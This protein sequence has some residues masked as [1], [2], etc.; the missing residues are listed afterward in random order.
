MRLAIVRQRYTPFGGA[1]RF[2]ERA[3]DAL[4]A[5][6]IEILLLTRHW[7][8]G[9][10]AKVTPQIVN[11]AYL[12][13]TMRDATFARGVCDAVAAMPGTLVQSHERI[14]CCDIYRSG[15][16]VHAVWVEERMRD[17]SPLARAALA[18][19]PYHRYM[20]A[21]ERRLYASPRL[22]RVICIS[23]MV[24]TEIHERFGL[25]RE[26]LPVIYNAIDPAV[27]NPGLQQHRQD[28]RA[29]C[30]IAQDAVVFLQVGS[31]YARKGVGRA[32]QALALLPPAAHLLVVGRDRAPGRYVALAR[33]LGVAGRVTFAGAQ[34]DPKP[35]YGAAD[36]FV[37]PTLYD[38][39]SNAVLEALAC[40]LPVVT[41][42]RCGAGE[43]VVA[44]QAGSVCPAR[45]I[46]GIARG[47]ALLLNPATRAQAAIGALAAM[48][49]LTPDAM[50]GRLTSLYEALLDRR[51]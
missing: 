18:A 2:V 46:E 19:S 41:S 10:N 16:G 7:P 11:P 8:P 27:F 3:L 15:D 31:A 22:Q 13:R 5:R 32:L 33:R 9:T 29:R 44:H 4:A 30:G 17:A 40:G 49:P 36:A 28:I 25:P 24:Q 43:L 45:D 23:Q 37:L 12:G 1:E 47:M 6:G 26:R 38:A 34:V 21:A 51:G 48:R 50:A 35:F 14:A 39:L 42:D 20:L